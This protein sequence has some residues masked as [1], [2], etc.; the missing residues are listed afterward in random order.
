MIAIEHQFSLSC[1]TGRCWSQGCDGEPYKVDEKPFVHC[2][3]YPMT[4]TL[5][6]I[7]LVTVVPILDHG[8]DDY[9]EEDRDK[10]LFNTGLV[11][12]EAL[13]ITDIESGIE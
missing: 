2:K 5:I 6:T 13:L 4:W 1:K 11:K 10:N 12:N 8:R 9:N 7:R 3:E